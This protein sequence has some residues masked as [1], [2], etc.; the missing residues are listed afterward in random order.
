MLRSLKGIE[1]YKVSAT[2]GD[3]GSVANFLVDDVGWAV[4]YLVVDTGGLLG[5][6]EVLITPIAFREVDYPANRFR[7]LLTIDKI[8]ASPSVNLDLPVSRQYESEYNGYYG[9]PGYWG[10]GGLW[11]PGRSPGGLASGEPDASRSRLGE[12]PGDA[13]LRSAKDV[14]GYH[15]EATDGA[16]GHV[17]DFL[18]D[19]ETW[20]V[21]YMVV[22]TANWWPGKSVLI[23]PAWA[24]RISWLD[25]KVY[26]GMTREAIRTSPEW[27]PTQQVAAAYEQELY[28]HY[29]GLPGWVGRDRSLEPTTQSEDTTNAR[30][31][32]TEQ[33]QVREADAAVVT[34]ARQGRLP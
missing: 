14:T 3:V 34:D 22:A 6:R 26:V 29:A 5:G 24:T 33:R 17:K 11:G 13:H 9:Y 10:W 1:K 12:P 30:V 2:D 23:S 27:N 4:R 19:D 32:R 7:L 28:R 15:I 8:K 16:I 18:V 31:A 20:E 21:R 25:R